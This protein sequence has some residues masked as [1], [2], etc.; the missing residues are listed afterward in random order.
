ML[1]NFKGGFENAKAPLK[2]KETSPETCPT[3]SPGPHLN[4][5]WTPPGPHLN[6]TWTPPELHLGYTWIF[7]YTWILFDPRLRNLRLLRAAGSTSGSSPAPEI[8]SPTPPAT[9]GS[10]P[11][12]ETSSPTP[13]TT[14]GSSAPTPTPAPMFWLFSY[15]WILFDPR[16]RNLR[17]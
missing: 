14:S 2:A 8:S 11:A 4:F 13:P 6:F 10:S 5:T 16:L 7:S 9:S 12:P 3:P 17:C 15:T 1:F